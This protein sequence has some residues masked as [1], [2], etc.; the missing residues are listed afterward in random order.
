MSS[1]KLP[2]DNPTS[3]LFDLA[4]EMAENYRKISY[5][6]YY[7]YIFI[8]VSIILLVVLLAASMASQNFAGVIITFAII[9]SGIM[10]LRLVIFTIQF[11]DDFYS[12]FEA[13]KLV[14]EI[15][16]LPKLATG[17]TPVDRLEAYL[18][19]NDPIISRELKTGFELQKNYAAGGTKWSLALFRKPK[20][21][22]PKGFLILANKITTLPKLSDFIKLEADLEAVMNQFMVPDRVI[23]LCQASAKYDGISDD[24]YSYLTDKSHFLLKNGKKLQYKL[25]LFVETAGRYEIIPLIP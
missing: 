22:G 25:Q 10:L 14:R 20:F 9:I 2:A 21:M 7:A 1:E 12:N 17:K 23:I 3:A 11:L 18:K 19:N 6:K 13:I 15:D 24:L 4:E 16:P 5:L 8:L